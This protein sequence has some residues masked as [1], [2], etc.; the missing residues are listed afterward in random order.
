MFY[1]RTRKL[2]TFYVFLK[3]RFLGFPRHK[4]GFFNAIQREVLISNP[5]LLIDHSMFN[6]SVSFVVFCGVDWEELWI[7]ESVAPK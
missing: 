4:Q 3:P 7:K 1:C 2:Y 6:R 5:Q